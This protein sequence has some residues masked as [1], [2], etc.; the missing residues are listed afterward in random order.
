MTAAL[1]WL[2]STLE[3]PMNGTEPRY[4][5]SQ[6][7]ALTSKAGRQAQ[8]NDSHQLDE[9]FILIKIKNNANKDRGRQM[10]R[11]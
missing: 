7:T 10:Q 9:N 3:K 2:A 11:G 6:Y 1:G 8:T 5:R 4:T